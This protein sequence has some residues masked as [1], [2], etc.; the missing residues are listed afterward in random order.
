MKSQ[1]GSYKHFIPKLNL[2]IEKNT[3]Q[4]PNDG[5]YYIVRDGH[6]I[7]GFRSLK[8]AEEK[9]KQLVEE[10][11]YKPEALPAKQRNASVVSNNKSARAKLAKDY[12]LITEI[13][14]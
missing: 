14:Y 3:E 2:S 4:V 11:G 9:F 8:K 12:I 7:E 5:K 6:A 13:L 1:V 10:S